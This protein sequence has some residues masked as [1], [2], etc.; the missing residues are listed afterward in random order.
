M[1]T[2]RVHKPSL[3]F[4][5]SIIN[6]SVYLFGTW[7]FIFIVIDGLGSCLRK[8]RS[9]INSPDATRELSGL[10]S[11]TFVGRSALGHGGRSNP[12]RGNVY[13]VENPFTTLSFRNVVGISQHLPFLSQKNRHG[14]D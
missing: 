3:A 14:T 4:K 12:R 10:F 9:K 6:S 13:P 11:L 1:Q 8:V 7:H 5:F 2:T